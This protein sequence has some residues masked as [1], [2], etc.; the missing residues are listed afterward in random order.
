MRMHSTLKLSGLRPNANALN[1]NLA[2]DVW[3]GPVPPLPMEGGG[4]ASLVCLYPYGLIRVRNSPSSRTDLIRL[5]ND[6]LYSEPA[7]R[8]WVPILR[9]GSGATRTGSG[10]HS[11]VSLL[12]GALMVSPPPNS[13]LRVVPTRFRFI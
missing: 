9:S 7:C 6:K 11:S 8:A 4:V 3:F 13:P 1:P 12:G 2:D 10:G 5:F